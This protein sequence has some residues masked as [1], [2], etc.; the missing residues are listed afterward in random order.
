ML[1]FRGFIK[2]KLF[3]QS[4]RHSFSVYNQESSHSCSIYLLAHLCVCIYILETRAPHIKRGKELS[5]IY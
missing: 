3:W 2:F 4:L 5:K 1:E